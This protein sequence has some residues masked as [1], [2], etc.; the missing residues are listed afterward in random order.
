V[1]AMTISM[2]VFGLL[3]APITTVQFAVV[4]DVSPLGSGAEAFSWYTSLGYV[5]AAL[6]AVL[7]GQLV[8][9]SGTRVAAAVAIGAVAFS[10]LVS[11]VW[12]EPLA[13]RVSLPVS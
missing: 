6:G 2:L 10:V 1:V 8:E 11:V 5:G 4:D 12:R 7:A 13:T 3:V 9:G